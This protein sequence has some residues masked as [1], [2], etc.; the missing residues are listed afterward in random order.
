M[1]SWEGGSISDWFVEVETARNEEQ[2]WLTDSVPLLPHRSV[3]ANYI[4]LCITRPA[5]RVKLTLT[6]WLIAEEI[7]I[8]L[9]FLLKPLFSLSTTLYTLHLQHRGI[10]LSNPILFI[11]LTDIKIKNDHNWQA[12]LCSA[13]AR[14]VMVF[15]LYTHRHINFAW[16]FLSLL[17]SDL[18]CAAKLGIAGTPA[19][20]ILMLK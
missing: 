9:N 8:T 3:F 4:F 11:N 15:A 13:R 6:T 14:A 1:Q 16:L 5:G 7:Q 10:V 12:L 19:V 20:L 2:D 17:W 18:S